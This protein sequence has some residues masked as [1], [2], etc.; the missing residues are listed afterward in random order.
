MHW[1][2]AN[3]A[4]RDA[5]STT[6]EYITAPTTRTTSP[7]KKGENERYTAPWDARGSPAQEKQPRVG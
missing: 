5:A 4:Q 2:W 1:S 7:G 3:E 6:G